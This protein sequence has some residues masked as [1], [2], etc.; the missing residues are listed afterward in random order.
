M[1]QTLYPNLADRFTFSSGVAC[2]SNS[3][4]G[5]SSTE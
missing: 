2:L 4:T 1:E 5:I 3:Y